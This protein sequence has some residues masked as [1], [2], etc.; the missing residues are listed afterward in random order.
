MSRMKRTALGIV[1]AAAVLSGLTAV[2]H[3]QSVS[4]RAD[5]TTFCANQPYDSF[6][7]VN[8]EISQCH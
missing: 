6:V 7:V 2:G 4:Q 8:G 3:L 1:I 5:V